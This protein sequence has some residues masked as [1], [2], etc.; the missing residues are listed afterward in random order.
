MG[1][2]NIYIYIIFIHL[3]LLIKTSEFKGGGDWGGYLCDN[4]SRHLLV[5]PSSH[6]TKRKLKLIKM[7]TCIIQCIMESS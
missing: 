2:G 6:G 7:N 4:S 1:G 3:C 5:K